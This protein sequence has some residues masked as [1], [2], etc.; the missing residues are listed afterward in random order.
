MS[1][2]ITVVDSSV[3]ITAA[4][5]PDPARRM[6]A[7]VTLGDPQREFAATRFLQLEVLPIATKYRKQKELNL[8]RRFF[9]WITAWLDEEPLIQPALALA[10]Q[11]G[12]GAMDALHLAAA[13]HLNAEFISAEKP[14]KPLYQAYRN[15]SSIY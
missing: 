7:V 14:T 10:C 3:L 5:G 13:I 11:Y 1:K 2:Q 8:Y 15:I 9:G 6:R 4:I 12:L